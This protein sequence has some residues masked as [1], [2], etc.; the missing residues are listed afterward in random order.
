MNPSASQRIL[1]VCAQIGAREHYAIPRVLAGQHKL[2]RLMTDYWLPEAKLLPANAAG[3]WHPELNHANVINLNWQGLLHDSFASIHKKAYWTAIQERNEWFQ[4]GQ[5][6]KLCRDRKHLQAQPPGIF[7]AYSYAA[8]SLLGFFRDLG[9]KTLL[10]QIDGGAREAEIVAGEIARNPRYQNQWQPP[11]DSYFEN[12]RAE[13]EL[14][15]LIVVNS[16][17]SHRLCREAGAP[18][19]KLR[20]LPLAYENTATGLN[21]AT[22]SKNYPTSFD[23]ERPLKVLFLGQINMRKGIH[24]L[25]ESIQDLTGEP[26]EFWLVGARDIQ[27]PAGLNE[28]PQI[29]WTGPVSRAQV[30]GYFARADVFVLPTLSDGFALTQLEAQ[31]W[32]V[33]VITTRNCGAVVQDNVNGLIID[34]PGTPQ[35]SACLRRCL[36]EPGLLERLS[37]ASRAT[38]E[39]SLKTLAGRLEALEES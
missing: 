31:A 10:G 32:Q 29:T 4:R 35:L 3:R 38:D 18:V 17:W 24:Y 12:L 33:P 22:R 8:R 2:E 1:W 25:L 36:N 39:F 23:R 26:V 28:H 15:D 19:H 5:L 37:H 7:F 21:P 34:P 30:S 27:L 9:W 16:S 14:A 6:E 13:H 20:L 11:P